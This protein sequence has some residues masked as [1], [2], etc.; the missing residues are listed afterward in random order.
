MRAVEFV[1]RFGSSQYV[2]FLFATVQHLQFAEP[3]ATC[4]GLSPN[5]PKKGSSVGPGCANQQGHPQV[6]VEVVEMG[7]GPA[8]LVH[9][10]QDIWGSIATPRA[11]L[12]MFSVEVLRRQLRPE[13]LVRQ[14]HLSVIRDDMRGFGCAPGAPIFVIPKTPTK[15]PF[16]VNCTLGNQAH[17]GPKPRMVLPNLHTLRRKF[18]CWAAMPTEIAA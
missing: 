5:S 16:I 13:A 18:L 2:Q 10:P 15:C 4:V 9:I 12:A 3:L 14:V 1:R 7:L 11:L 8:G 17:R 6:P